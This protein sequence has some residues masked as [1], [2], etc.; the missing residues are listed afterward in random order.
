[1]FHF[2]SADYLLLRWRTN[3]KK[4]NL[5]FFFH[6]YFPKTHSLMTLTLADCAVF[7]LSHLVAIQVTLEENTKSTLCSHNR[8]HHW[9]ISS[10]V[11]I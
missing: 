9:Q 11:N 5:G 2:R 7:L 6:D 4:H 3:G 8:L 1:M 10:H